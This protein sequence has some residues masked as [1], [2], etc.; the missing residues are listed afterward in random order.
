MLTK[1]QK[2][3]FEYIKTYTSSEGISP[4]Q[5]EIKEYFGFKSFGSV[6]RYLKYLQEKDLISVEWNGRRGI[7]LISN[8]QNSG[9]QVSCQLPL[10][11][12]IAAGNPIEAI[13][14]NEKVEVPLDLFNPAKLNFCLR[15]QGDSMIEKGILDDDIVIIEHQTTAESGAIIAAI[16]DNEATLKIFKKEQNQIKLYPANHKYKPIK[17]TNNFQIAGVLVGLLRKY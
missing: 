5:K 13:E 12:T 15:I 11:G 6:Q 3:V 4:T 14:E 1:K 17:V 8:N 10:L 9:N 2:E 7:Q 16:I